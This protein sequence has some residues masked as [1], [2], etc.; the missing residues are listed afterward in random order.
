M[1]RFCDRF[2][3]ERSLVLLGNCYAVGW[4]VKIVAAAEPCEAAFG[5]AAVVKSAF[6][7]DQALRMLRI[8]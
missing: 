6:T 3:L 5:C 2:T 1:L 8:W 4:V 7:I